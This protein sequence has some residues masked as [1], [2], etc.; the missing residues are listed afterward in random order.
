[1]FESVYVLLGTI[2]TDIVILDCGQQVEAGPLALPTFVSQMFSSLILYF[3][4]SSIII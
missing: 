3:L 2:H 1:M 4:I